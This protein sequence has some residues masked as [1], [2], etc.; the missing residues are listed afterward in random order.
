MMGLSG[1]KY[2]GKELTVRRADGMESTVSQY[3]PV[4]GT[5]GPPQTY[6]ASS[7]QD[8]P[9]T[10]QIQTVVQRVFGQ[11]TE[12]PA[13]TAQ[14]TQPIDT[15]KLNLASEVAPGCRTVAKQLTNDI[16]EQ[17]LRDFFRDYAV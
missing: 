3:N 2:R 7:G 8:G 5:H 14:N 4:V 12:I 16:K 1:E 15:E 11:K 6:E 17:D 9:S 13:I 10:T